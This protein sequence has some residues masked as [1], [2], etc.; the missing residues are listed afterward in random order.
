MAYNPKQ[1]AAA[2]ASK[3]AKIPH[4]SF[5]FW[6]RVEFTR[7]C[8]IWKGDKFASG[9]GQFYVRTKAVYAHRFA[10]NQL[11]GV[12]PKGLELD[13][14]CRN[15]ACV[16]PAH[17]EPV[18][19]RKNVIR[20]VSPAAVNAHKTHCVNGHRFD[21]RNTYRDPSTNNR[22]CRICV[23][24]RAKLFRARHPGHVERMK[25]WCKEHRKKKP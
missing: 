4:P 5:K 3:L 25:I 9:Y 7:D 20:G 12:V 16:R 18:P 14:L 24:D 17:L 23:N 19:H 10:W 15:R 22:S 6:S 1:L 11:I 8:W 21:E 2:R 13:H